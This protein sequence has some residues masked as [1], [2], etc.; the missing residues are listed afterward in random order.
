ML[1]KQG[2]RL[3]TNDN[4]LC[5]RVIWARY[6][7]HSYF[8]EAAARTNN[9][10]YIWQS[11]MWGRDVLKL[12]L[13]WWI[14]DGTTA[15]ICRDGWIPGNV[16]SHFF[17]AT[18][19]AIYLLKLYSLFVRGTRYWNLQLLQHLFNAADVK[20]I[21]NILLPAELKFDALIWNFSGNGIYTIKSDY[22]TFIRNIQ[23][24]SGWTA[25]WRSL[26]TN[27]WEAKGLN[28]H[29]N[30][31]WRVANNSLP[32]RLNLMDQHIVDEVAY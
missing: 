29:Q 4:S 11:L 3:I 8:M 5:S 14:R 20:V 30:F 31:L 9:A 28:K 26:W 13:Q 2:W 15:R 10:S 16:V 32:T 27:I 19:F 12:G 22:D 21:C 17:P 7:P 23:Q 18:L 1:A 24:A 25:G 6:Y